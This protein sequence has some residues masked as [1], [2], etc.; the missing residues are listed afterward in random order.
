V[1]CFS[2]LFWLI[3]RE[4]RILQADEANAAGISL[5]INPVMTNEPVDQTALVL[6][7]G[8]RQAPPD[9]EV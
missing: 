5:Q 4:E 3:P 1:S 6:A 7:K 2:A 8:A 9:P